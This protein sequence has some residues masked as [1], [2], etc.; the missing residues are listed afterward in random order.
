[1]RIFAQQGNRIKRMIK[2]R[3]V[4]FSIETKDPA[5]YKD[6]KGDYIGS[7]LRILNYITKTGDPTRSLKT[8]NSFFILIMFLHRKQMIITYTLNQIYKAKYL[9]V[10]FLG[11]ICHFSFIL[12]HLTTIYV[13]W[14]QIYRI[15]IG[16]FAV[17]LLWK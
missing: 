14:I 7:F 3:I 8:H 1:S 9:K 2:K 5:H 17:S 6:R 16:V 13:L 11:I 12:S 15:F 10:Q 4:Y